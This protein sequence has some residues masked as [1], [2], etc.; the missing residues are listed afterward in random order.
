MTMNP[1]DEDTRLTQIQVL[2]RLPDFLAEKVSKAIRRANGSD[3]NQD[4]MSLAEGQSAMSSSSSS[5]ATLA[6]SG[7]SIV[8]GF[9]L[10]SLAIRMV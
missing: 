8:D 7:S 5:L 1:A 6:G 3:S 2:L 9:L 4:S 10:E